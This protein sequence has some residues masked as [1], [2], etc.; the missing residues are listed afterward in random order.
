V[1]WRISSFRGQYSPDGSMPGVIGIYERFSIPL[2]SQA[3]PELKTRK[4][5]TSQN[6]IRPGGGSTT[7]CLSF[8]Q[9]A[10]ASLVCTLILLAQANWDGRLVPIDCKASSSTLSCNVPVGK[11][12]LCHVA[13]SQYGVAGSGSGLGGSHCG[14]LYSCESKTV[15]RIDTGMS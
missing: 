7:L 2:T 12:L 15:N 6:A 4:W 9:V 11:Q 13:S 5:T 8:V 14:K 1:R 3:L 10:I